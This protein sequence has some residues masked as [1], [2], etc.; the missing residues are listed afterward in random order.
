MDKH[1]KPVSL[2]KTFAILIFT[3][4]EIEKLNRKT[5]EIIVERS[6]ILNCNTENKLVKKM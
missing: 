2:S 6:D 5:R 3:Q 4:S 1:R